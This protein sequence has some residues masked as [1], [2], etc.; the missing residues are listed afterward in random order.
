MMHARVANPIPLLLLLAASSPP[1]THGF[2]TQQ[3]LPLSASCRRQQQGQRR[4]QNNIHHRRI[5]LHSTTEDR[6]TEVVTSPITGSETNI[7][8]PTSRGSEVDSRLIINYNTQ[9]N[10]NGDSSS[11]DDDGSSPLLALRLSHI[12]FASEELATQTLEKLTK[13]EW[14]FEEMAKSVSNCG[15]T[16]EEGGSVGWVNL[17]EEFEDNDD[18]DRSNVSSSIIVEEEKKSSPNE[19]LDLILPASARKQILSAPTKPGD[20]ILVESF[21]GVHLVQV[22]DVMV[23]VRKLSYIKARKSKKKKK[24][25]M[26]IQNEMELGSKRMDSHGQGTKLAG[27]LGGAL[28]EDDNPQNL[29]LTYKIETMGCQMN[30]ADSERIEGQLMSLGIRPL[31]DNE[32][33]EVEVKTDNDGLMQETKRIK[34]EK[35]KP[36]V[37]VLN[38]CSIRDHAEQ[39]VYS[40]LGPH[41]KRK[42]D[43]EDITI[44][45]AGC[46]AQQEGQSLLRRVPEID[47][48]MGPQYANR[49]SDLLEDVANGNQ[50]VATEA[51]HIMED[52]TKPRRQSSVAAWVNIIYGC[53]ERCT[54]CIVPTT[55]GVEQ[56]RPVESIV[57]E[58]KELVS[59]GFKEVTLLGQNIDAYGRD[60]MPKR[61]FSD[62]LRIVGDVPGLERLRF[63]TS[64]PRYM[65]LGVVDAVAETNAAC[66]YFHIPFQSGSNAVLKA[67]GRGHTREKF[68]SIVNRIR[69]RLP[70][71]AI[72]ADV[73]VGFPGETEEDFLDTLNLMREVKFD[74]VN[75]AAYSPRPNTPAATWEN[76]LSEEVKQ[77]RLRRINDLNA[78]H[79]EERRARM[80]GRVVEVLVEER[81]VKKP[82]QVM[83]RTTHGYIV[84]F[85]G[86]IDELRGNLVNVEIDTCQRYYLAGKI[87]NEEVTKF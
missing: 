44:I 83:G 60:M 34:Q 54:Y 70:D 81:N 77:D 75:T 27:V 42:R 8:Y 2:Q 31:L 66:E 52:S 87:T 80:M 14:N 12:L 3:S 40:Y 6:T 36:D 17:S 19:H 63:V 32:M 1:I 74:T 46:V 49:I 59:Q 79:A 28:L 57:D 35:K 86:D 61:K 82:T 58:V 48:V 85:D 45:V 24:E 69:Q 43:G 65:S 39:K 41:A 4:R 37:I 68:L 56:S 50:V 78:E 22:V 51:S 53:N 62:L 29:D 76:Q 38:T 23:D 18:G 25:A 20:I 47:L 7:K 11:S 9:N 16:R 84:Y 30:S 71:A 5:H 73:I 21:R 64:H 26:I 72:T 13:S 33:K 55:R 10:N 15:E 67:M